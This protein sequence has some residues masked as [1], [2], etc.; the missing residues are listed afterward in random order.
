VLAFGGCF[1]RLPL[2]AP[3]HATLHLFHGGADA[4]VPAAHARE[5]LEALG[6]LQGDATL[7]I[8]QGVGHELHPALIDQALW[9]LRNHIPARTWAAALGAVP[10]AS[11]PASDES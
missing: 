2:Q 4:V 6:A 11:L 1:A 10:G 8:A 5:A 3:R 9:R 7:D